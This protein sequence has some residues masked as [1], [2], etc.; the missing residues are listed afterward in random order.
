MTGA[1]RSVVITS[2]SSRSSSVLRCSRERRSAAASIWTV[3]SICDPYCAGRAFDVRSSLQNVQPSIDLVALAAL[4]TL[5]QQLRHLQGVN[6]LP[7]CWDKRFISD[8][9]PRD[10]AT[11]TAKQKATVERLAWRYRKQMPKELAPL[12]D[13][14]WRPPAAAPTRLK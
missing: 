9:W 7:G 3:E 12:R 6:M 4:E 8:V 10:P 11:L 5:R 14:D 2:R 1:W 13:P